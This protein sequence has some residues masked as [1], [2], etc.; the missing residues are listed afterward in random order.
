MRIAATCSIS[1]TRSRLGNCDQLT[2]AANLRFGTA[3]QF[4]LKMQS[5]PAIEPPSA[6]SRCTRA[7]GW[8]HGLIRSPQTG[9]LDSSV[10]VS[11][12]VRKLKSCRQQLVVI[13]VSTDPHPDEI[14]PA[15]N[16]QRPVSNPSTDRPVIAD[17]FKSQRW[18][19]GFSL[20]RSKFFAATFFAD[21]GSCSYSSQKFGVA[22]CTKGRSGCRAVL[23]QRPVM[24]GNP[25]SLKSNPI[26][27]ACP[28][29]P[30]RVQETNAQIESIE[31][32]TKQLRLAGSH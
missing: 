8:A 3:D 23:N 11:E 7:F 17:F 14:G 31:P 15:L 2:S 12:Y 19:A 20:R 22:L 32:R 13:A 24:Q 30:S 10:A 26:R 29:A 27:F 25:I 1:Q 16:R 18:V 6:A 28:I 9:E 21:P 5:S 4:N